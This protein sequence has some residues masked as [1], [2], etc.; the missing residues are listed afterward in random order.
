ML[1]V[2]FLFCPFPVCTPFYSRKFLVLGIF[3]PR[4]PWSS[5]SIDRSLSPP[6]EHYRRAF[7]RAVTTSTGLFLAQLPSLSRPSCHLEQRSTVSWEIRS[8]G[9]PTYTD[10]RWFRLLVRSSFSLR[11]ACISRASPFT[12]ALSPW[13]L[14]PRVGRVCGKGIYAFSQLWNTG[15]HRPGVPCVAVPA[16]A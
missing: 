3:P 11:D 6:A 13:T 7:S 16:I 8:G 10:L 12:S 2:D 1:F 4:L 9:N 15:V 5:H 14:I